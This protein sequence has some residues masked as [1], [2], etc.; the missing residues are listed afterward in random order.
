MQLP[1]QIT[2][3]NQK[4]DLTHLHPHGRQLQWQCRNGL[5]VTFNVRVVYS[6]HCV[7]KEFAPPVPSGAHCFSTQGGP[8]RIF[9][10][11]RHAWS[12]QLPAIIDD[13]FT[14]PAIRGSL[15]VKGNW[16][17]FKP[18]MSHKLLRGQKYY[19][20][21]QPY[22][23]G[24]IRGNHA[25]HRMLLQVRSAYPRSTLPRTPHHKPRPSFGLMIEQKMP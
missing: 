6:D 3:H 12:L 19:V 13:L 7:S 4:Y 21:L 14:K 10:P 5:M 1:D 23:K 18:T 25:V 11:D 16:C 24:P 15:T 17:I 22:Y 20:F 9:C 8:L 2:H